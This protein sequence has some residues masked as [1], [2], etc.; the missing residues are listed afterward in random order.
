MSL[1]EIFILAAGAG[2]RRD[3]RTPVRGLYLC[4]AAAHPGG[5]VMGT[6]GLN[7]AREI[8]G[9]RKLRR[10]DRAVEAKGALSSALRSSGGR[11]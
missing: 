10:G 9:R 11:I 8:L 2:A 5:G 7:A 3:Y 4:G 1:I 6:P